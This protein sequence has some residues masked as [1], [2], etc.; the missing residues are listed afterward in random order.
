MSETNIKTIMQEFKNLEKQY[1]LGRVAFLFE[2]SDTAKRFINDFDMYEVNTY[3]L[4]DSSIIAEC[5]DL[6]NSGNGILVFPDPEYKFYYLYTAK[7]KGK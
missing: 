7:W 2:F 6:L 5:K 1:E 3:S 4:D